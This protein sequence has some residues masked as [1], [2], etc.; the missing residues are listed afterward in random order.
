LIVE[1]REVIRLLQRDGWYRVRSKGSHVQF[2]H[3]TKSGLVTVVHPK[4]DLP[5]GTLRSIFRA[6]G[7]PMPDKL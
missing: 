3:A 2:K 7:L 6:A 5:I 4:K 1:S